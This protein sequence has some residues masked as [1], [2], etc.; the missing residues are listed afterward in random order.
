MVTEGYSPPEQYGLGGTQGPWTD[1]YA[2]GAIAYRCATGNAPPDARLRL[3][4]DPLTPASSVGGLGYDRQFLQLIDWMLEIDETR[5]PSSIDQVRTALTSSATEARGDFTAGGAKDAWKNTATLRVAS[6][7][8]ATL[9]FEQDIRA[10]VLE[11][12]FVS[13]GR[14][15]QLDPEGNSDWVH[16]PFF[17]A[18]ARSA[19]LGV[20]GFDLDTS[21]ALPLLQATDLEVSS[22]D[23]FIQCRVKIERHEARRR[24]GGWLLTGA[25]ALMAMALLLLGLYVWP[26]SAW[27]LWTSLE[28]FL[29]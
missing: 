23:E 27:G 5:R 25:V 12:C 19:D 17:Y 14:Y 28:S 22:I 9:V 2:L 29:R 10:D 4:Q 24:L 1:I 20:N 21:L 6:D 16:E 11:V 3:R 15:L 8:Q 7:R 18:I 26:R 13:Q